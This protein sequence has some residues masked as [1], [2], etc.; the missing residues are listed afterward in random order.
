M[1]NKIRS[2]SLALCTL[3]SVFLCSAAAMAQ[4]VAPA[5]R[6]VDPINEN[7]LVTLAG[8]THPA[9][10]ARTIGVRSAPSLPMTDLILV[11]SRSPEQQAAFDTFVASQ[12]ILI[13]PTTT[14]G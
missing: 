8:S 9:A 3:A 7:Q 2:R 4:R 11:L 1:I 5:V 14:S 10:N 6:I 12:M 13:R